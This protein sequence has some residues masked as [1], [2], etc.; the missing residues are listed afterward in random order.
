MCSNDA[1]C[2]V[3]IPRA[4]PNGLVFL[5][6]SCHVG[7]PVRFRSE[8]RGSLNAFRHPKQTNHVRSSQTPRRQYSSGPATPVLHGLATELG[9]SRFIPYQSINF[10]ASKLSCSCLVNPLQAT[11]HPLLCM[12]CPNARR[13]SSSPSDTAEL[14]LE[15]LGPFR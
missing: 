6:K 10:L 14:H 8:G 4:N 12:I 1:L 3:D 13:I 11:W 9:C 7:H 15:A 5:S 2:C